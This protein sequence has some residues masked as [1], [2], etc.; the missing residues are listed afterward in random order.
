MD[1]PLSF[2][3]NDSLKKHT[4]RFGF[5]ITRVYWYSLDQLFSPRQA[6]L[7]LPMPTTA[8]PDRSNSPPVIQAYSNFVTLAGT[9]VIVPYWFLVSVF[10]TN[11]GLLCRARPWRFSLR[12]LF[13]AI[14]LIAVLLG[15]VALIDN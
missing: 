3:D 13:V 14:T 2:P 12:D 5:G 8:E 6:G 1:S 11:A 9:G 15:L 7:L 4:S 10:A